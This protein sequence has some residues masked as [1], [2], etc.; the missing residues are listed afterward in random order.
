M[1]TVG[2]GVDN[3]IARGVTGGRDDSESFFLAAD[4]ADVIGVTGFGAGSR[5]RNDLVIA[6]SEGIGV[7]VGIGVRTFGTN[8]GGETLIG[9]SRESDSVFIRVSGGEN[10]FDLKNSSASETDFMFGAVMGTVGRGV[11]DPV[12]RGVTGGTDKVGGI[13]VPTVFTGM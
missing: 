11:G 2:R 12:A 13:I 6:M 3:P 4:P 1:G 7:A 9:T 10:L 8:V 5:D